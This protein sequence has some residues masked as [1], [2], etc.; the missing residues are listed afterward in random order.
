MDKLFI[1]IHMFTSTSRL[2]LENTDFHFR[3]VY[4][5]SNL[6]TDV[7]FTED[8]YHGIQEKNLENCIIIITA[9]IITAGIFKFFLIIYKIAAPGALLTE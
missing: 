1:Y 4:G 5:T 6:S 8:L 7:I 2:Y 9:V 3:P